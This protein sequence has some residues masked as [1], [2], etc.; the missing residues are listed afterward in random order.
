MSLL[1]IEVGASGCRA[2]AFS[3][4]GAVCGQASQTYEALE[5]RGGIQE[6][7]NRVVWACVRRAIAEA[8]AAARHDPVRALCVTSIDALTPLSLEGQVA[9]R[10]ILGGDS[11]GHAYLRALERDLGAERLFQITQSIPDRSHLLG[12]LRWVREQ[13]PALYRGAWRFVFLSGLVSTL[14]GGTAACDPSLASRTLLYDPMRGDWSGELL[15]ATGLDAGKLPEVQAAGTLIGTASATVARELGLPAGALI[16]LGGHVPQC[17]ALGAGAMRS[18]AAAYHMA[19][20]VSILAVYQAI[21]ITSLMQARGLSSEP[22]VVPDHLVSRVL[23][24]AG[25][26]VLRWFR[27]QL[28]VQEHQLARKRGAN[29]Y[30]VLL[31]E[32]PEEPTRLVAWP[33][34]MPDL[35]A[36]GGDPLPGAVVG[37]DERTTRGELVKCLLEGIALHA[38]ECQSQLRQVGIPV[39]FYRAVGGGA[40]ADRWLQLTA[41]VV[42]VPVERV[43]QGESGAAGAAALAGV[44]CGAFPSLTAATWALVRVQRRFEPDAA[45]HRAYQGTLERQ[46]ELA[47]LLRNY[48]RGGM[49]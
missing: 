29:I 13:D 32:M 33:R 4:D 23:N 44:G 9:G 22:H 41:D 2:M 46:R 27:D 17:I 49:H 31:A 12:T 19:H 7:D 40:R 30:D 6:L 36:G 24:P 43:A 28:A 11:R 38:A 15:R 39:E 1:G 48:G 26:T 37:L 47:A 16:V 8:V 34:G 25:G 18:G 10:T 20:A 45:R 21:P 42:G 5:G 3:L 14:L 35:S